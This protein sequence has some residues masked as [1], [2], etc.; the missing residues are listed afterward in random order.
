MSDGKV[1]PNNENYL[2]IHLIV[3]LVSFGICALLGSIVS[4]YPAPLNIA[5]AG[6]QFGTLPVPT[7][8]LIELCSFGALGFG[9]LGLLTFFSLACD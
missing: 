4:A 3:L 9:A 5:I 8:N 6:I 7:R 2:G 1:I